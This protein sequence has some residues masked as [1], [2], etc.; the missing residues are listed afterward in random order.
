M[1]TT[2][3]S[4]KAA[5][6]ADPCVA[7]ALKVREA[8]ALHNYHRFFS[9]ACPRRPAEDGED[10]ED[11]LWG[12]R[13]VLPWSLDRERKQA[14]KTILKSYG[15]F[16]LACFLFPFLLCLFFSVWLRE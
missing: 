6:R 16:V 11:S 13:R 14:L 12:C 8:W 5:H 4:F 9:L 10:S 7:F 1:S 15:S 2:L 3:S